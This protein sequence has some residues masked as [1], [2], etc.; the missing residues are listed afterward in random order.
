[1]TSR[2]QVLL[3]LV[4]ILAVVC[5]VLVYRHTTQPAARPGEQVGDT[6]ASVTADEVIRLVGKTGGV[7]IVR[8]IPGGVFSG[9]S[10]EFPGKLGAAL[11]A[12]PGYQVL[13]VESVRAY[14]C[15]LSDLPHGAPTPPDAAGE[16]PLLSWETFAAVTQKYPAADAVISLI[17]PPR[18]DTPDGEAWRATR[19]HLAVVVQMGEAQP[20][21]A[22]FAVNAVDLAIVPRATGP[23]QHGLTPVAGRLWF[24]EHYEILRQEDAARAP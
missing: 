23:G 2:T 15:D 19:R 4:T 17:G 10:D 6:L 24:G 3:L 22:A 5:A 16:G 18:L 1:M 7:V 13:G 12:L 8:A 11:A 9:T 20:T 21:R 14:G